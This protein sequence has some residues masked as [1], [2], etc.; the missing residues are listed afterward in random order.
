M[1]EKT[2]KILIQKAD[3]RRKTSRSVSYHSSFSVAT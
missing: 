1:P 2:A 3:R